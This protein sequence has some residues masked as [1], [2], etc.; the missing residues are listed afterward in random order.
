MFR[1]NYF[2]LSQAPPMPSLR[3]AKPIVAAKRR[4]RRAA[5][6]APAPPPAAYHHGDLRAALIAAA[7]VVL[8]ERGIEGLTLRE[9]ARRA[10]VSHGAPAHHFGD[11]NGLLDAIGAHA[12]AKLD[13]RMAQFLANMPSGASAAAR[14]MATGLGYIDFAV[15]HAGLFCLAHR[16]NGEGKGAGS[17]AFA[18]LEA[19]LRENMPHLATL[20]REALLPQMLMRWSVVHGFATLVLEGRFDAQRGTL[21]RRDFAQVLGRVV[22][23]QLRPPVFA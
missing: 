8:A 5:K 15:E 22:L 10:G 18:R 13:E 9:C 4:P 11:I 12:A 21:S 6:P 2:I 14:L 3:V 19:A 23:E 16:G 20:P 7:E 1:Q 17:P